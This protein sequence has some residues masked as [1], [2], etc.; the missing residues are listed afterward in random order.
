MDATRRSLCLGLAALSTGVSSAVRP[1][2]AQTTELN[3]WS[4]VVHQQ[5]VEGKRGGGQ[6]DLGAAFAKANNATLRW[7]TIAFD[8]MQDKVLRELNLA[9]STTDIVFILNTWAEPGVLARLA[10][11]N[12]LMKAA[13]IESMGDISPAMVA[14]FTDRSGIKG[15]PFRHNPQLLHY[16]RQ[17][18]SERGVAGEPETFEAFLEAAKKTTFKRADGAQVYGFAFETN[19]AEDLVV[20]IR[21]YGGEV[22][23][24]DLKIRV[25]EPAPMKAIAAMRDLFEAGALPP[26]LPILKPADLQNL[27]SQGLIAMGIF[28]DNYYD[29]FNDARQSQVA[30]K[31]WFA[32]VPA[33]SSN[34]S[35]RYA[36]SAGFWA[37][38]IPANSD[39]ARRALSF[40]LISFLSE[41][42]NQL[43]LALNNNSPVRA[44]TYANPRYASEIPYAAVVQKVLPIAS[45]PFPAFPG[46]KEA[47]RIFLEESVA[48]ITGQKPVQRAMDD[49][50]AGIERVLRREGLR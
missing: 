45:P 48:A 7:T 19:Q 41:P 31:T 12:D 40:K 37:M 39:S 25:N 27:M 15:I 46:S 23:T 44:T 38:A 29:R 11:M 14:A 1:A 17:I 47:E 21:A 6:V 35:A 22:I 16:N 32:P 8:Q 28:G 20:V 30:G 4:H 9:R 24:Q 42:D 33:S 34:A 26:N 2:H 5:V 13:P 43:T 49:A 18:F 36:S 3:L 10:S 50:A